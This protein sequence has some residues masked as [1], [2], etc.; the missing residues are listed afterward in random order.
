MSRAFRALLWKE[1]MEVRLVALPLPFVYA[2][3]FYLTL[4]MTP[5]TGELARTI[6]SGPTALL[7]VLAFLMGFGQTR[8]ESGDDMW[9]FAL[10]RPARWETIF[11][12]KLLVG[13]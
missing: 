7:M 1:W 9:S 6:L 5:A 3:L 4:D 8:L 12:A 2:G 10:H 11:A 13:D